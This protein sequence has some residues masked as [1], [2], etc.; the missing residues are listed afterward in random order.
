M[1]IWKSQGPDGMQGY[2]LKTFTVL[3]ERIAT[4]LNE[5]LCLRSVPEWLTKGKIMLV[6]KD[7]EKGGDVSNFKPITCL[8]LIWKL[9]IGVLADTIYEHLERKS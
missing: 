9:F 3:H 2:W 1:P 5:C 8:P 7:K 6:V 4:Q